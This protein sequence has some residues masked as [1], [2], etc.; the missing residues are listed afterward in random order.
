MRTAL[1][2][3]DPRVTI[4]A[5]LSVR[6]AGLPDAKKVIKATAEASTSAGVYAI[7]EQLWDEAKNEDPQL[8]RLLGVNGLKSYRSGAHALQLGLLRLPRHRWPRRA[9]AR[10]RGPHHRAAARRLAA[11]AGRRTRRHRHRASRPAGQGRRRRL[12][13]AHGAD[14]FLFRRRARRR[15]HLH[16][17][18]LRQPRARG[19]AR[20]R[21]RPARRRCGAD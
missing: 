3:A 11:G 19:A 10:R 2:D 21:R 13:R 15:A 6:R 20:S 12:W 4:Q 16:P 17:Q 9:Q 18:Q 1:R 14:E 7:N 8:I 5:M